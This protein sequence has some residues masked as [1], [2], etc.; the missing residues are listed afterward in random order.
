[1]HTL[2]HDSD[3]NTLIITIKKKA[4]SFLLFHYAIFFIGLLGMTAL[5]LWNMITDNEYDGILVITLL[6][7]LIFLVSLLNVLLWYVNGNEVIQL[8]KKEIIIRKSGILFSIPKKIERSWIDLFYYEERPLSDFPFHKF[9][10]LG[11]NITM[12]YLGSLYFFG[13]NLSKIEGEEICD[14]L[15]KFLNELNINYPEVDN[16]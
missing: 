4:D 6:L 3:T 8:N 11:G 1:M 15:N 13:Q 2:L 7:L 10:F 5:L 14:N 16:V 12:E 9:D